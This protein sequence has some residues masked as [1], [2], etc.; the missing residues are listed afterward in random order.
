MS[1]ALKRRSFRLYLKD[2][3]AGRS[4]D[5]EECLLI[6]CKHMQ[7]QQSGLTGQMPLLCVKEVLAL[8]QLGLATQGDSAAALPAC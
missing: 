8:L 5:G 4:R 6:Y 2:M 1:Y 7:L 3:H